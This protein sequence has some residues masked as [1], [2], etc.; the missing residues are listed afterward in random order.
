M[1]L[2]CHISRCYD[3]DPSVASFCLWFPLLQAEFSL[4]TNHRRNITHRGNHLALKMQLRRSIL[5]SQHPT[6][7][8]GSFLSLPG[9][10][11]YK[12]VA[13]LAKRYVVIPWLTGMKSLHSWP[14]GNCLYKCLWSEWCWGFRLP[15]DV[16]FKENTEQ[17]LLVQGKE[18]ARGHIPNEELELSLAQHFSWGLKVFCVLEQGVTAK[19]SVGMGLA[20]CCQTLQGFGVLLVEGEQPADPCATSKWAAFEIFLCLLNQVWP[21]NLSTC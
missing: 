14:C 20:G 15:S 18:P 19:Q 9:T 5:F 3:N 2:R 8:T 1:L 6:P 7:V 21:C 17:C 12:F 16:H 13:L 11:Q 10:V 4:P